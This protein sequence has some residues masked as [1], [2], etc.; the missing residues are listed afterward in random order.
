MKKNTLYV[1]RI[2]SRRK[3]RYVIGLMP[4]LKV[5]IKNYIFT[6]IARSRGAYIG[7]NVTLPF[8]LAKKANTNL[9]V[10]NNT[11]IQSHLLDLRSKIKIGNNVIIGRGVEI[12]TWSHNIDS[13]EWEHK[14]YGIEIEDFCWLATRTFI[15]PSCRKIKEGA[16]CAAGSVVFKNVEKMSVVSGNPAEHFKFREK[17]HVDLVVES[18]MAN[19]L[20]KYVRTRLNH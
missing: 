15:L 11:V 16:V 17:V 12:I 2:T 5:F 10:G 18:L 7:R 8:K 1:K 4:R 14:K 6:N 19:D 9:I 3:F 20:I 13:T